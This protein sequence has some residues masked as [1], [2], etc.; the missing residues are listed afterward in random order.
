[1]S[2]QPNEARQAGRGFV[3]SPADDRD[4]VLSA[5]APIVEKTVMYATTPIRDQGQ[6]ATCVGFSSCAVKEY[7]DNQ[8]RGTTN[9]FSPNHLYWMCKQ[10]DGLPEDQGTYF[11]LGMKMLLE[12]GVAPESDW[13]YSVPPAP[14]PDV[15][16][17]T[18]DAAP[19]KINSYA[20][21]NS[22]ESMVASLMLNGPFVLGLIVT[23][24]WYT[25]AAINTGMIDPSIAAAPNDGGHAVAIIGYDADKRLF[26]VKNSWGTSYGDKGYVYLTRDWVANPQNALEAWAMVDNT[27]IDQQLIITKPAAPP[28]VT[29]LVKPT[30]KK[31]EWHFPPFSDASH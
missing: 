6:R 23:E 13:P 24:G 7:F 21:L 8:E 10:Q 25:D 4:Y 2:M 18:V 22:V 14:V 12:T 28:P 3:P 11:R 5:S 9:I 26:K 20:R 29:P 19:Q 15:S 16:R 1:M 17:M 31:R 27:T 30:I